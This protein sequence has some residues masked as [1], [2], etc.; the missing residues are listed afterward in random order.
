MDLDTILGSAVIAAIFSGLVSYM[1]FRRQG[2]LQYITGERK[3]WREKMREIAFELD[4]ASY[5]E[6]LK[7]LTVLKVRINAFGN[8]KVL[9][10]YSNDAHIWEIISE[11]E[12]K[13]PSKEILALKQKQLIEY[14][15]LL[16]KFDWERSKN[17]VKGNMYDIASWIMFVLAS[18]CFFVFLYSAN[19][20]NVKYDLAAL[21]VVLAFSIVLFYLFISYEIKGICKCIL[22]GVTTSNA[23]QYGYWRLIVCYVVCACVVF[24]L[25]ILNLAVAQEVLD[26]FGNDCINPL[27][28]SL[29]FI[30]Y[31]YGL[32]LQYM[33][34][35][36]YVDKEF[37][38]INAINKIRV[39]SEEKVDEIKNKTKL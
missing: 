9:V 25:V 33:S 19:K 32:V 16:L 3:E 37:Y 34:Q 31:V 22:K 14:I 18:V 5:K 30:L 8:N 2:N 10:N 39:I 24:L 6:T 38:Y 36:I 11:L 13:K 17:E 27:C 23:K 12:V 7:L 21:A 15:S 1:I 4:G 28:I 20:K 26:N 35:I 29:V